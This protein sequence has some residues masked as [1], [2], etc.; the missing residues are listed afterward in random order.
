MFLFQKRIIGTKDLEDYILT[1]F[2][3]LYKNAPFFFSILCDLNSI[4]LFSNSSLW[5]L[6]S[7]W[8]LFR[9]FCLRLHDFSIE[10][11]L[12]LDS[13]NYW[14]FLKLVVKSFK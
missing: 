13:L 10:H 14:F 4:F 5:M 7:V 2:F 8:I 1:M 9:A 12:N 6:F 3:L 11:I